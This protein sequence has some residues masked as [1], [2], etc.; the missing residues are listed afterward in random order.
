MK[1]IR[2]NF[3]RDELRRDRRYPLPPLRVTF[4]P[5]E[6]PG[7]FETANWSLGGFALAPQEDRPLPSLALGATVAGT[8]IPYAMTEFYPFAA[9]V[10]RRDGDGLGF[11]FVEKSDALIGV[12]DR[13]L[14]NRMFRKRAS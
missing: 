10:V 9:E 1:T 8:L 3:D 14:S 4:A 7:E 2:T 12:L 13:A 5:R 11:Q 6:V